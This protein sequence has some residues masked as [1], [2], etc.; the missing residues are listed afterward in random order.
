MSKVIFCPNFCTYSS[1][2]ILH[3]E[4]LQKTDEK[5]DLSQTGLGDGIGTGDG[6]KSIGVRVKAVS[7]QVDVSGKVDSGTGDD[8]SK[9][10]KHG[11]TSVLELDVSETLEL[12][13]ISI[14]NKAKRI[15]E[16]KR[17]LGSKF[18]LESI[19]R[20]GGGG[21]L[22]GG[23]SRGGGNKGGK[24]GELHGKIDCLIEIMQDLLE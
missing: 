22:S 14:G 11:D 7:L 2:N 4:K 12:G 5:D 24:D 3:D 23:K 1:S 16:S 21:L 10:G 17:F 15:V 19:E 8:L 9:E 6:G 18:V 20:S 13:F